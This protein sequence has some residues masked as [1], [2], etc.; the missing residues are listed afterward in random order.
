M[1]LNWTDIS[2]NLPDAPTNAF[3]VDNNHPNYL[4]LGTEVG[5]FVSSNT[6]QSWEVLGEGLPLVTIGD[7]KIH[8]TD[9]FLVAGTYGR[10]MYKI[11]LD[12][13]VGIQSD[14]NEIIADNFILEQNY[15][16]PFNPYTTIKFSLPDSRFTVLKVFDVLGNEISTLVNED[17]QSG[18]HSVD[19]DAT[20]LS[21]GTYF[22][23]IEAGSFSE[24][25]KMI[26]LK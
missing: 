16:N 4:Y 14:E 8:P 1:G 23:R 3:A 25:K 17:K 13:V 20:G 22:Y 5:M 15:P 26:V 19:F 10:G 24:T 11:N 6:G 12:N 9:N 21:S 2:G 7:I 18:I